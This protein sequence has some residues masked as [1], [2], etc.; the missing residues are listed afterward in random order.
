MEQTE[1]KETGE[2]E[3]QMP[4]SKA[5]EVSKEEQE[6]LEKE[7]LREERLMKMAVRQ[8]IIANW[9]KQRTN[10]IAIILLFFFMLVIIISYIFRPPTP[11]PQP[12]QSNN[13]NVK[14]EE[15]QKR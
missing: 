4:D 2:T 15:G 1:I 9:A 8:E 3:N 13:V 12:V 10:F 5:K 7:R 6:R 11:L 14:Q